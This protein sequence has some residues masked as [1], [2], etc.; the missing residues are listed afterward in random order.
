MGRTCA[1]RPL[2]GTAVSYNK[3]ITAQ[4]KKQRWEAALGLLATAKQRALADV[5]GSLRK[6][7]GL[8]FSPRNPKP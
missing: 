6:A 8:Q 2:D 4:G 3:A 1:D 7:E 5:P